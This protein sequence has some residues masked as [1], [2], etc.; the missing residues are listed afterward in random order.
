VSV[1]EI[2]PAFLPLE[3]ISPFN[4]LVGP[5]YMKRAQGGV[6]IGL[7]IADKHRNRRDIVHGGMICTLA[8]FAMGMACSLARE[9]E[10]KVVTTSLSVDFAGNARPGDWVEARVD[11]LRVGRRMVFANCQVWRDAERIAQASGAFLVLGAKE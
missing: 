6:A 1:A 5:L 11:V 9:P 2:P 4:D 10:L 3:R 8:D 7:R